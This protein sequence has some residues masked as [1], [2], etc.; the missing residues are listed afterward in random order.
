[1]RTVCACYVKT[2]Q[3]LRDIIV[4]V[5]FSP[6][7]LHYKIDDCLEENREDY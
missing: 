7:V 1:M 3:Y 4:C 5:M 6:P 2:L